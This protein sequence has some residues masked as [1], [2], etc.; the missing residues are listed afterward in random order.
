M[1]GKI[2]DIAATLI[3]IPG[4]VAGCRF[5]EYAMCEQPVPGKAQY[6]QNVPI[7]SIPR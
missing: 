3:E 6:L 7:F 2:E 4:S 5:S 1:I